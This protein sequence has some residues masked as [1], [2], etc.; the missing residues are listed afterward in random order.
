MKR[1]V[2]LFAL[3]IGLCH[4]SYGQSDSIASMD[5]D[6]IE[7][8]V[9]SVR[10]SPKGDTVT[11]ELFLHSYLKSP[12]ELKI[13]T[14]ATGLLNPDG[15][16]MFYDSMTIGKVKIMLS[17]RQNYLHY[18]LKRNEPVLYKIVTCNWQKRWG[19]PQQL[20]LTLE[21][22]VEIGK[23]LQVDIPL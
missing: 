20:R 11:V 12:R 8:V 5:I 22:H 9:Q 6:D 14:F 15:K 13:N 16:P 10:V 18:L 17:D 2:F 21:D 7:V 23:F 1:I 19:K 3:F 4:T